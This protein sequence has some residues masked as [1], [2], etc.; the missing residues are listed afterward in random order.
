MFQSLYIHALFTVTFTVYCRVTFTA[1]NDNLFI[2]LHSQLNCT[3]CY[4]HC[5]LCYIHFSLLHSTHNVLHSLH[6]CLHRILRYIHC[7][8]CYFHDNYVT[9]T[10]DHVTITT[11]IH[12]LEG[13]YCFIV[14]HVI[15]VLKQLRTATK[16]P[17]RNNAADSGGSR[18]RHAARHQ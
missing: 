3:L 9:F 14:Q 4:I 10:A 15:T 6:T 18:H 11:V 7:I 17:D 13:I 12:Y 2:H 1:K 16:Q 8:L 5:I